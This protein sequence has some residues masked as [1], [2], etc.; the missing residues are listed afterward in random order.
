M[1][2]F[3]GP[4]PRSRRRQ[5]SSNA[6]ADPFAKFLE[7]LERLDTWDGDMLEVLRDP[8]KPLE[9]PDHPANRAGGINI[10]DLAANVENPSSSEGSRFPDAFILSRLSDPEPRCM[11]PLDL[12]LNHQ[13]RPILLSGCAICPKQ[14]DL[15]DCPACLA[16][17]YCSQEHLLLDQASHEKICEPIVAARERAEEWRVKLE[18]DPSQPFRT[19][20]GNL[21]SIPE[22]QRYFAELSTL[23]E[24][25]EPIRHRTTVERQLIFAFHIMYM[26]GID[27]QGYRF[28]V[29]ALMMRINRDQE[30][31]D[32]MKWRTDESEDPNSKTALNYLSLRFANPTLVNPII[33]NPRRDFVG[34]EQEDIF[35]PIDVFS[36]ETPMM[37]LIPLC[38]LKIRFMFDIQRM[39][40]AARAFGDNLG[41]DV[42]G[43]VLKNVP[44][45]KQI[46]ENQDLI[47]SGIARHGALKALM[48]QVLQLY[49]KVKGMNHLV[50]KGM[51][52]PMRRNNQWPRE[53]HTLEE[54]MKAQVKMNW[55]SWIESPGAIALL[56]EIM[57]EAGDL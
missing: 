22:A 35:E 19:N 40:L 3:Y 56:Q 49:R 57:T 53:D 5:S 29:P 39:H 48:G 54:E 27:S 8:P 1:I 37:T 11:N 50:W 42:L 36:P 14:N 44:F 51:V 32:F 12:K 24:L 21:H 34:Y 55:E 23:I 9:I 33:P 26:S 4:P 25:H 28:K 17:T 16:M 52:W 43:L 46:A 47:K 45:T 31:Y 10:L 6:G 30:C 15:I 20:V 41:G 7:D 13:V 38:L 18:N 2:T